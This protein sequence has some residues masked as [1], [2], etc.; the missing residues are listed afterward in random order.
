[1]DQRTAAQ[2]AA[3]TERVGAERILQLTGN[4][5]LTGFT[6]P[7]ILWV[8]EHEPDVDRRTAH[9]LLPKDYARYKLTD[10]FFSEVSDASGTSLFDVGARQWSDEM[11][12]A[13]DVPRAWLPT[14]TESTVVSAKISA[15][16]ARVTGL[17][18]GTP[19]VGGGGDQAAQAIGTGIVREGITS[20]TVGTSGVVF[21]Q[22][23]TYR[24]EPQ[25]R[26]HAF[27]H[28]VPGKWHLMGVMLSAAGS[29]RWYRDAL[30]E[31]EKDIAAR[32]NQEAYDLLT[33][34]AAKAP[35]GCE[36]LL[37]LPYLTGERTPY[38]NPNARGVFFGLT[39]RHTKSHLTRAIL[40]GVS[41]GLRDSLELLRALGMPVMHVRASG[42]GAR[43]ALWRQILA[44]V[45]GAELVTVNV[46]EGAAYG[47]ALLAGV[48]AG[49]YPDVA[50]ACDLVIKP[51]GST[52]PGPAAS[53][54]AAYYP[55]Y[56]ALYPALA[57]EFE[58]MA[59]VV[60]RQQREGRAEQ[61]PL[62][63]FL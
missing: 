43:S 31:R 35:P 9:I 18:A 53:M 62:D 7:K 51:T 42:G 27:C 19:V 33:A 2:C 3:I 21:A 26:L 20:V 30:G 17:V 40:E 5:V 4:P 24:V 56:R 8:R 36:G 14:V 45:F 63:S 52:P 11:L 13:L 34:E 25:G 37:F 50:S 28:A 61:E 1:N 47:A 54:Y 10:E 59:Q 12:R 39:V 23:D 60:E 6:A 48:G 22:S 57:P 58:A 44:D 16:A 32:T 38:A 29:F 41:F 55:R 15:S 49:V 46:T